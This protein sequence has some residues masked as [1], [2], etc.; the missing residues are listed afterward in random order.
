MDFFSWQNKIKI[1]DFELI[2]YSRGSFKTGL[3]INP[4]KIFLDAGVCSQYEPNLVL[5]THGHSDH[6]NELFSILIANSRKTKVPVVS[7]FNLSKLITNYLNAQMSLSRGRLEKYNKWEPFI[8]TDKL[9]FNIQSK[10]IEIE[11][12]TMDHSVESI[13]FG[14]SEIRQKLKKEFIDKSQ[15]ELNDIRKIYKITEEK[16]F[17]MF[18]FCG[19]TG[20]SILNSLPFDKFP[21]I[22]IES[23]FLFPEHL[24]EAREKK[25][26][27]ITDLDPYFEKHNET[28]FVL[29][30][31]S[32]R[33]KIDEIKEYQTIYETKYKNIKFFV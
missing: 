27:H 21:L 16:E 25:H 33:Y 22:I 30:H 13:G 26:L 15:D 2:G 18:F 19:D 12:Y 24:S 4:L 1:N 29:I 3:M 8:I 11:S 6:I 5:I 32:S 28:T 17:P 14:V 31:F 10:D 20:H 9:R 23:T 7:T